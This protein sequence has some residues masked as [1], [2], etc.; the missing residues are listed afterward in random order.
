M[1]SKSLFRVV[2]VNQ[3]KVYEVYARKVVQGEL[4]GFV[5]IEG[6]SFGERSGVVVDPSEERLRDEFA[7]VK[8]FQVPMHA[9]I[10]IDEVEKHGTA[11]IVAM[12]GGTVTP[13]P[14]SPDLTTGKD[15]R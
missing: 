1:P 10:R 15:K 2:F 11:R 14:L 8:R 3:G 7:G 13:F 12:D 4:L 5:C 6:L 9:V